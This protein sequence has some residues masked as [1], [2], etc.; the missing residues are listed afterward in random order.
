MIITTA[1]AAPAAALKSQAPRMGLPRCPAGSSTPAHPTPTARGPRCQVDTQPTQTIGPGLSAAAGGTLTS[2]PAAQHVAHACQ[3][4]LALTSQRIKGT[5]HSFP[6]LPQLYKF[7]LNLTVPPPVV[8]NCTCSTAASGQHGQHTTMRAALAA[9]A[10]R[11]H[12][13]HTHW[14]VCNAQFYI[15]A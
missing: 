7:G 15:D 4:A 9:A 6:T 13:L 3:H 5:L 11:E 10:L 12:R 2:K 8:R 14:P 1:A